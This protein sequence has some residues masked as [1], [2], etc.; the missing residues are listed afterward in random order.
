[1]HAT[2]HRCGIKV[3]GPNLTTTVSEM[4]PLKDG[5]KIGKCRALEE[6]EESLITSQVV[7]VST[8]D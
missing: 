8:I 6:T 7:Q 1:M 4:D 3:S 5:K 2:E